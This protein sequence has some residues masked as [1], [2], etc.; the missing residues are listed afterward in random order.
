MLAVYLKALA[1]VFFP[2]PS[3]LLIKRGATYKKGWVQY[4]VGSYYGIGDSRLLLSVILKITVHR[5]LCCY[6]W[7]PY[8]CCL[9]PCSDS[10]GEIWYDILI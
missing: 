10:Y 3:T 2:M 4:T 9:L 1:F 7:Y 8:W 6:Q 5:Y